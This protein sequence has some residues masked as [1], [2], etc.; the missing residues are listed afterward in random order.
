MGLSIG[1][2]AAGRPGRR[3]SSEQ[4]RAPRA[5]DGQEELKAP[6]NGLSLRA[7]RPAPVEPSGQPQPPGLQ[8]VLET[9]PAPASNTPIRRRW[10]RASTHSCVR[11]PSPPMLPAIALPWAASPL[12]GY[13]A[14]HPL[15]AQSGLPASSPARGC[16][17]ETSHQKASVAVATAC[18]AAP[19]PSGRLPRRGPPL[20]PAPNPPSPASSLGAGLAPRPLPA[21]PPATMMPLRPPLVL[22][23]LCGPLSAGL[24]LCAG[25]CL[26]PLSL[27]CLC[28]RRCPYR[29]LATASRLRLS[30]R[31]E[32]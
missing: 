5:Q 22:I 2:R 32:T 3:R 24:R 30:P 16:R 25:L 20:A 9:S 1:G 10:P 8:R 6:G 17:F 11:R 7:G 19:R 21:S 28:C 27:S 31:H 18:S 15:C 4:R 14:S 13:T 12:P 23:S 29:R 26:L